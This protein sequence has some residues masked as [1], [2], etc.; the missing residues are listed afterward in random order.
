MSK[1][2]FVLRYEHR[3]GTDLSFWSTREGAVAAL[4]TIVRRWWSE[5]V[6]RAEPGDSVPDQPPS[7]DLR[8]IE[9]YFQIV[10]VE[11]NRWEPELY[12]IETYEVDA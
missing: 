4:A 6:G 10:G 8:A 1:P 7:D 5:A 3:H 11:R 12:S 2:I 9:I